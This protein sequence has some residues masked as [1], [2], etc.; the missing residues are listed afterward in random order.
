MLKN[1]VPNLM[2]HRHSTA[3]PDFSDFPTKR[4]SHMPSGIPRLQRPTSTFPQIHS[5]HHN[6]K[7]L[8]FFSILE[9]LTALMMLV[10]I[11]DSTV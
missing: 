6:N 9:G 5:G 2:L 10:E 8:F 1:C 7:G 3:K 4:H 11:V